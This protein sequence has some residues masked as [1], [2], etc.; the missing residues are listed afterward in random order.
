MKKIV[1]PHIE[2]KNTLTSI[3][4]THKVGWRRS[5][6]DALVKAMITSLKDEE[7]NAVS[8]PQ[9]LSDLVLAIVSPTPERQQQALKAVL[10]NAELEMD[11]S[12]REMFGLLFDM[13]R[14]SASLTKDK[15]PETG[16]PF[17]VKEPKAKKR[18]IFSSLM[19]EAVEGK[20]IQPS[21]SK[22][23]DVDQS[24]SESANTSAANQGPG[25]VEDQS[26]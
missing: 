16:K 22:A 11:M 18:D 1:L 19:K 2:F 7:G 5:D 4:G 14:F 24:A 13:A 10:E 15:N 17:I 21:E 6:H 23:G 25:K 8:L 26:Q 20:A 3:T 12:T 9:P